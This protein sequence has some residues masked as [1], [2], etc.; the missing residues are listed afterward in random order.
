MT[1]TTP[2]RPVTRPVGSTLSA[3]A[4][5]EALV[6][7]SPLWIAVSLIQAATREGFDLTEHPLSMLSTGSLGWL[8]IANFVVAGGL[9]VA[10][11][12]GLKA[13]LSSRW[14]PRLVGIYG[15][16]Y[17]LSG[18][19][20]LDPGG[21]F[22]PGSPDEAATMSWHAGLH[23]VVGTIAFL[24]LTAAL[25]MLGRHLARGG[26]RAWSVASCGGAVA[27]IVG[28][29]LAS[30]QVGSASLALAVGVLSGMLVLSAVAARLR[31]QV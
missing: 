2:D 20:T 4:L 7:S 6:V 17:I 27:V 3:R 21:G 10:G 24:A 31:A 14:I 13:V 30:A 22:P 26:D 28:N 1:S 12:F 19:F 18:V 16:G 9:A 29:V 11:A 25:I 23:L 15:I 8:Q 5:L